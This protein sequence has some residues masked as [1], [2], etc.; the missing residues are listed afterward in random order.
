VASDSSDSVL[1]PVGTIGGRL[2]NDAP[3]YVFAPDIYLTLALAYDSLAAPAAHPDSEGVLQPSYETMQPRLAIGWRE[4]PNGDWIVSLRPNVLSHAGKELTAEDLAWTLDR[5]IAQ[6]VMGGWRWRE[7]IGVERV[8]II[9]R[10]TLRYCLRAPYPTF[11]NWLLSVS[12]NIVDAAAVKAG[13]TP[14]D[15]WGIGWL[16]A[17]VAGFG[18]FDLTSMDAERL[19]Y[20]SRDRYWQG[21]PEARRVEIR[22]VATRAEAIGLL[23]EPRPVVLVGLDPDE[24][25]A[26]LPR[27]DLTVLRTWAGHVSVEIDFTRPPFDDIRVRQAL[28]CATPVDRIIRDGLLGQGRPWRSPV[29]SISQ[30]YS[31]AG[32]DFAFDPARARKLLAEAGHAA[33]IASELHVAQRADSLRMAEI[34]QEAWREVGVELAMRDLKA[35][36]RG[37]L[38]PLFLRTECGHN[39]SEPVYDIVHDYAA[40]NPIFPLPGGAPHVGNWTPRW[41]K[42]EAAIGRIG[43]LLRERDRQRRR[44]QFDELQHWLTQ[45][46]S[47]IFIAEG[48]QVMASNRHVPAS[49]VSPDSRFYQALNHQN[50]TTNYLPQR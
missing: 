17:H 45:F 42:N 3:D 43:Q 33:G 27:D 20:E 24:T 21:R 9:D 11:P 25:A 19:I 44:E 13:A 30:W 22:R 41:R 10:H 14:D 1:V 2:D 34:I 7:V 18:A 26:L 38:P 40:M 31:E 35:A 46:C 15:P 8:E 48:Q 50:C 37:W 28:A 6:G 49:L 47:S 12:P 4:Q 39:L 29:K 16:N 32:W 36:P 23:D 5:G